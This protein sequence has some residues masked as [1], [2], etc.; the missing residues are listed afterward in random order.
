MS[1]TVRRSASAIIPIAIG[2]ARTDEHS[3]TFMTHMTSMTYLT[4]LFNKHFK[5]FPL[6]CQF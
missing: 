3:L 4:A 6:I 5:Y 2:I 1:Q